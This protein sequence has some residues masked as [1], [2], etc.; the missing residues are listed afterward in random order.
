MGDILDDRRV[1]CQY[2]IFIHIFRRIQMTGR[3]KD[4]EREERIN[5]EIIVDAYGPEEQAM[6]WYNYLDDVL[7]F[8]FTARCVVQRRTSPLKVGEEVKVTGM[9]PGDDC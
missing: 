9:A 1:F 7:Q 5:M 8:P 2:S 3:E 4:E 6:G